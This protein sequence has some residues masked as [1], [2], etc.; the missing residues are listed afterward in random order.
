MAQTAREIKRRMQTVQN[1]QQITKAMEMIAAAKLRKAQVRVEKSRPFRYR[2]DTSLNR[3]LSG[4]RKLGEPLPQLA[5]V[6]EKKRT[7]L[8][9]I[10]ADRGLSGSYNGNVIRQ[11]EEF[12]IERPDTY[13]IL[14]GRRVRDHFRRSRQEFLA[15]YVSLG[16]YPDIHQAHEISSLIQEFYLNGLFDHVA[17]LYTRFINTVNH[18]VTIK[19]ILPIEEQEIEDTHES[20]DELEIPLKA[21]YLFEPSVFEV[22]DAMI[23]LYIDTI[24]FQSLL[25]AASS[26]QGATMTAMSNASDNAAELLEELNLS[27]NRI[28]QGAI[29][30][31]ISE[32]V[33]GAEALSE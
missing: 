10:G 5:Q 25:E 12:L 26:Q 17:I 29:T 13:M 16:D 7:C 6:T 1:T 33:G 15:D 3:V 18:K 28:R 22:L 9:V 4:A 2:L 14:I 8:V 32:I 11:A 23:P 27:F 31:E 20:G 21:L 19:Q 30:T 24:I